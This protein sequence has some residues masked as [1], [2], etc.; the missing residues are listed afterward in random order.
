M[1]VPIF[2]MSNQPCVETVV[3]RIL[4]S[5]SAIVADYKLFILFTH[6]DNGRFIP[7]G[8]LAVVQRFA[9]RLCASSCSV[10]AGVQTQ[11]RNTLLESKTL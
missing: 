10:L 4:A 11:P 9:G 6:T 2:T 5:N 3:A 1:L 8:F 7:V